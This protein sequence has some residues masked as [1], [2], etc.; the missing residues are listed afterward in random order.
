MPNVAMIMTS[1]D[2][3]RTCVHMGSAPKD[4]RTGFL[5]CMSEAMNTSSTQPIAA[6]KPMVLLKFCR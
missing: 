1:A 4:A 3:S 2:R 5:R 6:A